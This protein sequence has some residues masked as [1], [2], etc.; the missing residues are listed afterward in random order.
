MTIRFA[1]SPVFDGVRDRVQASDDLDN[2]MSVFVAL[3][4]AIVDRGADVLENLGSTS[5]VLSR[6]VFRGGPT[7]CMSS[8]RPP[9]KTEMERRMAKHP[10][11]GCSFVS[12]NWKKRKAKFVSPTG[13]LKFVGF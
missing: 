3:L 5:N 2:G 12:C 4:E 8:T 10:M 11:P 13:K 7:D 6:R 9:T 1:A